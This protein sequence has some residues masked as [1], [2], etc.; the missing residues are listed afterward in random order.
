MPYCVDENTHPTSNTFFVLHPQAAAI[1]AQRQ[2]EARAKAAEAARI[3]E[4]QA[5][6]AR[7]KEAAEKAASGESIPE[8][9]VQPQS[10]P[11]RSPA[12]GRWDSLLG[13]D[14]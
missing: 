14:K 7:A 10:S 4:Q 13:K 11:S 2:R 3:A 1:E 8:V 6:E 9:E 12:K 5:E